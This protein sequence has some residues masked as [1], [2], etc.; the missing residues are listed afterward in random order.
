[1]TT[2]AAILSPQWFLACFDSVGLSVKEK[3]QTIDFQDGRY[4]SYLGFS[5]KTILAIFDLPVTTMLPTKFRVSWPFGSEEEVKS[6]FSRWPPRRSSWISE[7]DNFSY[8]WSTSHPKASYPGLSQLAFRF[9]S[10]SEKFIFKMVAILKIYFSLLSDFHLERFYIFYFDLQI[11]LMLPTK[12]Q[13][14]A[15]FLDFH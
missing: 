3:K 13:V 1:M 2:M 7:R 4:G 12:F 14:M 8:F 15:P 11:T 6:R 5:I 9:R 10:R